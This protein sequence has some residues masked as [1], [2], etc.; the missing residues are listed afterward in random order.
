MVS[1]LPADL[2]AAL[3]RL[4]HIALAV[5]VFLPAA[6]GDDGDPLA[7]AAERARELELLEPVPIETVTREAYRARAEAAVAQISDE[8]LRE[9]AETYGRLGFFPV[10]TNLRPIVAGSR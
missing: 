7:A 2:L 1:G 3:S 5:L 9:Y 8:Q 4:A 10:E 6:C